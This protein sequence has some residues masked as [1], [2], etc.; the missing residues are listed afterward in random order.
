MTGKHR[1]LL[2]LR[3][4]SGEEIS[5]I[6]DRARHLLPIATGEAAGFVAKRPSVIANMFLE[7]STRTRCS[8]EVSAYRLG[9]SCVNLTSSGSSVSKGE[10]LADTA[11]TIAAMGVAAIVLRCR[12]SGGASLVE[13]VTGLPVINAGDGRH[14]HPTQGLL[15]L[16][17][18][19]QHFGDLEGRKVLIVGDITNSRVARSN[20]YGLSAM[21]AKV[22]LVGPST[23]VSSSMMKLSPKTVTM[24]NNLDSALLG[25]DAVMMLR[26]QRERGASKSIG[27]DYR[28]RFGMTVER[29]EKLASGVP[30]LHPGPSN[31]GFEIDDQVHDDPSRSLVSLQ[32]TCGVAVRMAILERALRSN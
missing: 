8:F 31:R 28:S 2:A 14:E 24:G 29:A 3:G 12:E 10:S 32:V 15:D 17:A 13:K 9:H 21:G 18:L 6:L 25:A 1:S 16:L 26:V 19:R 20:I 7:D 22:H 5:L 27:S 11:R 23:L 4:M 30:I